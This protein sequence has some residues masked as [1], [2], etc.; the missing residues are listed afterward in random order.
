MML[1]KLSQGIGLKKRGSIPDDVSTTMTRTSV[2]ALALLIEVESVPLPLAVM[3]VVLPFVRVN[4]IHF[5]FR[6]TVQLR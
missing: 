3:P 2:S 4:Q 6:S 1:Q 5:G